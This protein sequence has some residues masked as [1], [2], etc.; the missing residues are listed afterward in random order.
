[1]NERTGDGEQAEPSDSRVPFVVVSHRGPVRFERDDAGARRVERPGGGLVTALLATL[2]VLDRTRFDPVWVCAA[3]TDEDR[4]V[5]TE[6]GTEAMEIEG[7]PCPVRMLAIDPEEHERFY[8][9]FSNP[10]LWFIQ[11]ELWGLATEP[12]IGRAEHDAY[13]HGYLPVNHHFADAVHEEIE[14]RGGRE[15][16]VMTHDYHFYVVPGLIRASHPAARLHT[17]VHVPWPQ[18]DAWRVLPAEIRGA[19]LHGLLGNDVV[20]F[21]THRYARNF[22][23]SCQE[24]LDLPVDLREMVARVGDREVAATWSPLSVDRDHLAREATRGTVPEHRREV[25]SLRREHLVVR[26]DRSD[27]SKNIVRG[28]LAYDLLLEQHPELLGRV[29]FLAIVPPSRQDVPQYVRYLAEI[30]DTVDAINARHGRDGWQPI[31]LRVEE[32]LPLALAA[33][34]EYDV[35][36]VNSVAD[37]LNLVA[38]EGIALNE[39]GGMLVLSENA[40]AFEELGAFSVAVNPFDIVQQADALYESLTMDLGRRRDLLAAARDVVEHNDPARWLPVQLDT[41]DRDILAR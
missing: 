12:V 36:M 7:M 1:M 23:L 8:A 20:G 34:Q 11:H 41:L 24:L 22:L 13:R 35:L 33:Y 40:G 16:V 15:P 3:A 31:D 38:K 28:F 10:M 5:A 21:H 30:R 37:G 27:P 14:R 4:A 29:T 17:F 2:P 39:R 19:L 26:V 25:E 32:N 18:P 9:S 6:H